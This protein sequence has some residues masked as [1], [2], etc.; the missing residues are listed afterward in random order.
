MNF[1]EVVKFHGHACP[2]LTFGFRV[3]QTA[4]AET[5]RALDAEFVRCR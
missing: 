4:L 3:S 2:G 1:A 5:P